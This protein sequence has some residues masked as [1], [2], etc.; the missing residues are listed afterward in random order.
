[1]REGEINMKVIQVNEQNFAEEVLQS[2]K[3]VLVDIWAPWC[4]PCKMLGPVVEEIAQ[5]CEQVKVVKINA[6]ESLELA[7][8]YDVSSI[9]TLLV[10]NDGKVVNRSVGLIPKADILRMISEY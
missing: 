7:Q 6:D 1:M 4:G 3:P 8:K 2:D 5:E 9:P 10:I